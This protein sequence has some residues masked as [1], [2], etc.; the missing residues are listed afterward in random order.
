MFF[1][2]VSLLCIGSSKVPPAD[3]QAFGEK[4]FFIDCVVMVLQVGSRR[5]MKYVAILRVL[6]AAGSQLP[7]SRKYLVSRLWLPMTVVWR[8]RRPRRPH[9]D[10]ASISLAVVRWENSTCP[11]VQ[12][13]RSIGVVLGSLCLFRSL[14]N[15]DLFRLLQPHKVEV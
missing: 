15:F 5:E 3:Q 1:G 7:N 6:C 2:H 11:Q 8:T 12:C 10:R 9:Q 4:H 13:K 14:T